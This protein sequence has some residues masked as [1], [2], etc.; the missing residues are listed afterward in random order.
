MA[1]LGPDEQV[2]DPTVIINILGK[3]RIISD[4]IGALNKTSSDQ[5]FDLTTTGGTTG[6][7]AAVVPGTFSPIISSP[8]IP[9]QLEVGGTSTY[10]SDYA[11]AL[12]LIFSLFDSVGN[13]GS[14]TPFTE[15]IL[16]TYSFLPELF[17]TWWSDLNSALSMTDFEGV[18]NTSSNPAGVLSTGCNDGLGGDFT[19]AKL[20]S[21]STR[22][23]DST[24]FDYSVVSFSI[25]GDS[26]VQSQPQPSWVGEGPSSYFDTTF[27]QIRDALDDITPTVSVVANEDNTQDYISAYSAIVS[28]LPSPTGTG[29]PKRASLDLDVTIFNTSPSSSMSVSFS[30]SNSTTYG[31]LIFEA[32]TRFCSLVSEYSY[33]VRDFDGNVLSSA[34]DSDTATIPST[35]GGGSDSDST[36]ISSSVSV[37]ALGSVTVSVANSSIHSN[38]TL[39]VSQPFGSCSHTVTI[40]GVS[41]TESTDMGFFGSP[42]P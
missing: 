35:S 22:V 33:D 13:V 12:P 34:S 42:C 2:N 14:Q 15:G 21:D 19:G 39:G 29:A 7:T 1:R 5:D 20:I 25:Q 11:S 24:I 9:I 3:V 41:R 23:V 32:S 16:D 36:S 38:P 37:P 8:S 31:N 27:P 10:G 40:N 6:S 30:A 17:R 28:A 26:V 18:N 4:M